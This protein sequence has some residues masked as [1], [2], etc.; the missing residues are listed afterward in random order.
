[1]KIEIKL[2]HQKETD[3]ELAHDNV[4]FYEKYIGYIMKND[5]PSMNKDNKFVFTSKITDVP[6]FFK[7]TK[8]DLIETLEKIFNNEEVE[9][10][11]GF[12]IKKVVNLLA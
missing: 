4:F 6:T 11:C 3:K 2:V 5:T 1:M 8:K 10:H 9:V 12:G 7:H